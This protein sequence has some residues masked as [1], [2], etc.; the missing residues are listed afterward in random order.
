MVTMRDGVK[1]A[2]DLWFP[3][4]PKNSLSAVLVRTP[5]LKDGHAAVRFAFYG[6]VVVVQDV[7]GKNGSEGVFTILANDGEDGYDAIDWIVKQPW[8]NGKVGTYGCS[9]CGENQL[10]LAKKRHPNHCAMV[11]EAGGGA[12]G[13]AGGSYRYAGLFEGGV[14][15]LAEAVEWFLEKAGA[16]YRSERDMGRPA[17]LNDL[18]S[19]PVIKINQRCSGPRTDWEA[20]LSHELSDPWWEECGYITDADSFNVP[21]LHVN[22]WFDYGIAES[23][24]LF[25]LLQTNSSSHEARLN[26]YAI[27]YPVR[28]C[29][30]DDAT[31]NCN[32]GS[33]NLGNARLD[34]F[35]IY[36]KWFDTWLNDSGGS[37]ESFPKVLLYVM[38]RNQWRSETEWPP[39][40]TRYVPFY[41]DS[42]E[43]SLPKSRAHLLT[44][45]PPVRCGQHTYMYDPS[46]PT[47]SYAWP[48]AIDQSSIGTRRDIL[49]FQSTTLTH[50]IDV[51]GAI[52]AILHVSSTARDTDFMVKLLDVT[53]SGEAFVI[54]RGSMRTR[55]RDGFDTV[56]F[57]KKGEVYRLEI[58]LHATSFYFADG[59]KIRLD[60]SSSDFPR[61]ERNLN[62][63]GDNHAD[64]TWIVAENTLHCSQEYLSR[65]V[66]P[67]IP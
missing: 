22:S 33:L 18:M 48:G 40:R 5:Y 3:I 8:S 43:G 57:M 31:E 24:Y 35:A 6:Y 47:P 15:E 30:F 7:R 64:T 52:K 14:P 49:T 58:D 53:P 61:L 56:A 26:Q 44:D 12:I 62:T 63:G 37:W 19:L 46:D 28:H 25:N 4:G 1:L 21:A 45:A 36:L 16:K 23:L 29:R 39:D 41:L 17:G 51:T 11:V 20:Y 9:Y 42:G 10:I 60:I 65:L 13:K 27:I 54:A 34:H 2:T 59:H 38:G 55:Y 32:V 66:L 67:V 50:G